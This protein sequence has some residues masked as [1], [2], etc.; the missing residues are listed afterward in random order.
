MSDLLR[1]REDYIQWPYT[2][3]N[4]RAQ[5]PHLSLSAELPDH[6]LAT[7]AD[8]GVYVARVRPMT[9]PVVDPRT[10]K[11][12]EVTPIYGSV[13]VGGKEAWLQQWAVRDATE[14][15]IAA[16]DAAHAPPPDYVGF[17]NALMISATYQQGVLPLVL[18]GSSPTIAGRLLLF[19][20]QFN[21]ARNG[22]PNPEALQSALWILLAELA[23]TQEMQEELQELLEQFNLATL[24]SLAPPP[25]PTEAP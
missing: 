6:E 23:P 20:S 9:Q 14:E 25:P 5:E 7:L 22:R 16:Y 19:E 10:K 24:Y 4:L 3:A 1:L 13:E 11:V 18:S 12:E 21:E 2:A 17:F 15:E 8:V